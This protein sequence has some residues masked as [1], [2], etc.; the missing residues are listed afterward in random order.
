MKT[1]RITPISHSKRRKPPMRNVYANAIRYYAVFVL[2][3]LT[4]V[5]LSSH[6]N[7]EDKNVEDRR[8]ETV[9]ECSIDTLD[10]MNQYNIATN[11]L[12]TDLEISVNTETNTE[13]IT[14]NHSELMDEY[15]ETV[16]VLTFTGAENPNN[17]QVSKV[18]NR[19]SID[20]NFDDNLVE[21]E[22]IEEDFNQNE[23]IEITEEEIIEEEIIQEANLEQ[24][25][26]SYNI[27]SESGLSIEQINWILEDTEMEGLGEVIYK[28]EQDYGINSYY[29]IS[30]AKLESGAGTSNLAHRAN[31]L[32]GLIGCEF[33]SYESCVLYF[34]ELMYNY[35]N[36]GIIMTPSGIS[37]RYCP[38]NNTWGGNIAWLMNDYKDK[39]NEQY[40]NL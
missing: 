27:K 1:K 29:T 23:I 2:I 26:S 22:I 38:G 34:G 3:Y 15:V 21:E 35:E 16:E 18:L 11:D 14:N 39:I 32:F 5:L 30:V 17:Q 28:I 25:T 13:I 12:L 31:N 33:Q 4:I 8:N 7:V 10:V 6:K 24:Y 20:D 40:Y 37:I 9:S 36:S 19:M